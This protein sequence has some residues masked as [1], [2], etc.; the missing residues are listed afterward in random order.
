MCIKIAP[1]QS[2]KATIMTFVLVDIHSFNC[3]PYKKLLLKEIGWCKCEEINMAYPLQQEKKKR[4]NN[5]YRK[6]VF[7]LSAL[8]ASWTQNGL[9]V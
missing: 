5:I 8:F 9:H 2:D 7:T 4:R 1:D 6:L 3:T